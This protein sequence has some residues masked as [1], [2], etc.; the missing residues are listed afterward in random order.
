MNKKEEAEEYF[1]RAIQK[2]I[3]SVD[4]GVFTLDMQRLLEF[5]PD[6]Y[7][8]FLNKPEEVKSYI[9]ADI[10]L[11]QGNVSHFKIKNFSYLHPISILRVEH[12]N[13]LVKVVGMI[14]KTTKVVALVT[15]KKYECANCGTIITQMTNLT[16]KPSM[17][18]CGNRNKFMLINTTEVDIQ[19]IELE[20][21][22]EHIEDKQPQK[23]RVRFTEDLCDKKI[24]GILQ[25]GNK[26]EIIGVVEKIEVPKKTEEQIFDYRILAYDLSS[27]E[28]K[29]NEEYISEEDEK[30]I[31]EIAYNEPLKHLADSLAPSIHGHDDVKKAIVLQMA[32]GVKRFKSDGSIVRERSHILL[33]GDPGTGKSHIA[34]CAK[35]RMPKS[36]YLSGDASTKTGIIGTVEH[37]DLLNEWCVKAGAL[38]KANESILVIDELDKAD[39]ED[40]AGLHTPMESGEVIINKATI[41]TNLKANCSILGVANPKGGM[42]EL[43]NPN[44]TLTQQI[45][46]PPALLSRFDLIFVMKDTIDEQN[47]SS[48]VDAIYLGKKQESTIPID[49]FRKYITFIKKLQPKRKESLVEDIKKFYNKVRSQSVSPTSKMK[50]MPI[51]PRH[52]EGILRLAEAHA[53]LRLSEFIEEE[54]LKVAQEL[55]VNSLMKLGMDTETGVLDWARFGTGRTLNRKNKCKLIM[56]CIQDSYD[57]YGKLVPANIVKQKAEEHGVSN[58]EFEDLLNELTKAGEILEPK[59]GYIQAI[60]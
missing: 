5:N 10:K 57:T 54:D 58:L 56:A 25:P 53:K 34:K 55:F 26:I 29:Y 44:I 50:G 51:T 59:R 24:S 60:T 46:L 3:V 33:C 12:I 52:I 37:D 11:F 23:I 27:L 41:H 43:E 45:D 16:S 39:E 31:K 35:A 7:E 42:F 21:L 4:A 40:R 2:G 47:D 17:C 49:L 18:S 9:L 1:S 48:I 30:Q 36:Y 28:E 19:E 38:S 13:R 6:M 20:E 14:S 15:M 32:G 22:Q 8:Y